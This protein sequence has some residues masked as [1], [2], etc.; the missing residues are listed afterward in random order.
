MDLRNCAFYDLQTYKHFPNYQII[1]WESCA[2]LL[3][4]PWL[5][6]TFVALEDQDRTAQNRRFGEAVLKLLRETT[7]SS[8]AA[9]RFKYNT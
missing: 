2:S 9:S 1:V 3:P 5:E 4:L 8:M 7:P 6:Y